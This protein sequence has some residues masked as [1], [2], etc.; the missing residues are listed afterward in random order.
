[1]DENDLAGEGGLESSEVGLEWGRCAQRRRR[2][3]GREW[4]APVR[5]HV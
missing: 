5:H 2:P 1:V 4:P 3:R